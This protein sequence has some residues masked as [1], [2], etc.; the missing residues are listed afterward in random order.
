M[1]NTKQ[2]N[3][4][5]INQF[6]EHICSFH[7][8][9]EKA[10]LRRDYDCSPLDSQTMFFCLEHQSLFGTIHPFNIYILREEKIEN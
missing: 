2:Y 5:I 6:D 3:K 9:T 1:Y 8:C 7:N 4:K 10:I